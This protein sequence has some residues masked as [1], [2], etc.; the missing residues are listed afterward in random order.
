MRAAVVAGLTCLA[1]I[2]A[3]L[4][5]FGAGMAS[6]VP[7]LLTRA[8][9]A[10]ASEDYGRA[11]EIYSDAL[12]QSTT[13]DERRQVLF[14]RASVYDISGQPARAEVDFTSRL[15]LTPTQAKDYLDRGLF[16]LRRNRLDQAMADFEAG[17]RLAPGD[18]TLVVAAG[19]VLAAKGQ[20]PEAI[21]RYSRAIDLDP[22][23]AEG[24]FG[25]GEAQV[26]VKRY[27]EGVADYDK[28]MELGGL[29]RGQLRSLHGGRG[30]AHLEMKE[31]QPAVDDFDVSLQILPDNANALRLRGMAFEGLGAIDKAQADYRRALV[32]QPDNKWLEERLQRMP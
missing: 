16:Y 17:A 29:T 19:R 20:F 10:V 21:E 3:A 32:L 4:W 5:G 11:I 2:L 18:A 28:A 7:A 8:A 6:D 22:A 30:Y 12:K 31:F 27:R 25:R 24:W 15:G 9:I 14:L 26:R 1:A 13:D 23:N